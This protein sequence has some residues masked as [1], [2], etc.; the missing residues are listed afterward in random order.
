[1][2]D[3]KQTRRA[4]IAVRR[5]LA[6]GPFGR[7]IKQGAPLQKG[8]A[9]AGRPGGVSAQAGAGILWYNSRNAAIIPIY[10]QR[11]AD[12]AKRRPGNRLWMRKYTIPLRVMVYCCK[13]HICRQG[14]KQR[15]T[16]MQITVLIENTTQDAALTAEHGLSLYI[17]H[18]GRVWLLDAGAS[19]AFAGNAD[20]LGL[21]LAAVD[22][23]ILSHG[24]YDHAGGLDAFLQRNGSAPVYAL[25]AAAQPY[26][27]GDG[28]ARHGIGIPANVLP[29][30]AGRFVWLDGAAQPAPGV[31]LLPHSTPGLEKTG[32]ARRLYRGSGQQVWPDD[33]RH[34]LTAVFETA[35]GLV[36]VNSCSHAGL[37]VILDEVAAQFPRQPIRAFVG[38]LHMRGKQGGKEVCLFSAAEVAALA[39]SVRRHGVQALYTGHCTGQAGYAAIAAQLPGVLHPL[40]TGMALTLG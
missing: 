7:A 36:V 4:A 21:P 5:V 25:R 39:G 12:P 1:M 3:R 26:C 28:D 35:G 40:A 27:S 23:A 22:A 37:P 2:K 34:E 20:A 6:A 30:W 13:A 8:K 11:L 24:H 32:A 33:F 29:R 31:T 15:G 16:A 18:R 10:A 17:R 19:G 14:T 9:L 38:G